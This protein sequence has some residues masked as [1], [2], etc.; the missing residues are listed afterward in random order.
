MDDLEFV[1]EMMMLHPLVSGDAFDRMRLCDLAMRSVKLEKVIEKA[2]HG[3]KW[4]DLNVT[5]FRSSIVLLQDA[6]NPSS[7]SECPR[8][9]EPCSHEAAEIGGMCPECAS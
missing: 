8:C 1:E 3:L 6:L 2:L 4:A 5:N 9:G 7:E